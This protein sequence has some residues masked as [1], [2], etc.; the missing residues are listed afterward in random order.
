MAGDEAGA[1]VAS[2]EYRSVRCS[3]SCRF[4]RGCCSLGHHCLN[5]QSTVQNK[6]PVNSTPSI[7]GCVA[8]VQRDGS[9]APKAGA[10]ARPETVSQEAN[11][12]EPTGVYQLLDARLSGATDAKPTTY[13]LSGHEAE[14]AK[15]EGQRVGGERDGR[16]AARGQPSGTAGRQGRRPAD[17]RL[18][19]EKD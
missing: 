17:S 10:T 9:L 3:K 8:Q 13:S 1:S 16:A 11:N 5:A 18:G 12:P 7:Q 4:P 2:W 19:R 6:L 15:L 14:F